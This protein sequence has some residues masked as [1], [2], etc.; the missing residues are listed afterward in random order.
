MLLDGLKFSPLNENLF[1]KAVKVAEKL[2]DHKAVRD[3]V[4][5]LDGAPLD[6]T[7]RMRVE[8]ALFEGRAGNQD[9]ARAQFKSLLS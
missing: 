5:G 1:I 9:D 3:L 6:R 2:G 7:W 4:K 8:G